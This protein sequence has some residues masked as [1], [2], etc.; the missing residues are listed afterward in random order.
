MRGEKTTEIIVQL[1][2]KLNK[3][4]IYKN[5]STNPKLNKFCMLAIIGRY[6]KNLLYGVWFDKYFLKCFDIICTFSDLTDKGQGW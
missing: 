1:Q 6:A 4:I 5:I 2:T 3:F